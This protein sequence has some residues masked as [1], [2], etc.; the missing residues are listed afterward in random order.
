MKLRQINELVDFE[1]IYDELKDKYSPT[2][3][4]VLLIQS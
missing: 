2:W 4:E 1:F 3:V